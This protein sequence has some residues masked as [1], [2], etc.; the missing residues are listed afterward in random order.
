MGSSYINLTP[1]P[2]DVFRCLLCEGIIGGK[3]KYERHL[4][5]EHIVINNRPWLMYQTL[6][7]TRQSG[8]ENSKEIVNKD[9]QVTE[10]QV[11]TN[12]KKPD[13]ISRSLQDILY[14]SEKENSGEHSHETLARWVNSA[15]KKSRVDIIN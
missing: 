8:L 14:G 11:R 7:R 4:L 12:E 13:N 2:D 9:V 10:A 5:A 6:A 3:D 15:M 1:L